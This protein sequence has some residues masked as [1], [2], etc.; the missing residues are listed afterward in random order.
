MSKYIRLILNIVSLMLFAVTLWEWDRSYIHGTY[1]QWL[2][3]TSDRA[4]S[5]SLRLGGVFLDHQAFAANVPRDPQTGVFVSSFVP[6]KRD[7]DDWM[8]VVHIGFNRAGFIYA[9]DSYTG[10]AMHGVG[11]PFWS[12]AALMLVLP[13]ISAYRWYRT[14]LRRLAGL[15]VS[16][17]YDLQAS[18]DRCPECGAAI[19]VRN[20]QRRDKT[21]QARV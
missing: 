13:A 7:L 6:A 16:C 19:V 11:V 2:P 18:I 21:G 14:R 20:I 5:V 10:Y 1:L 9:T 4:M 8:R 3:G 12:L 17:G 15:C